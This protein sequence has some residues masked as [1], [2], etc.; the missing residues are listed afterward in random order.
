[1]QVITTCSAGA[2][3]LAI[4]HGKRFSPQEDF[5]VNRFSSVSVLS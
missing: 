3:E 4:M 2:D 5:F 1:M